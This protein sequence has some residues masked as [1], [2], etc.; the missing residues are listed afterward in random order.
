MLRTGQSP[1]RT[2]FGAGLRSRWNESLERANSIVKKGRT[3]RAFVAGV[4]C[5]W[6]AKRLDEVNYGEVGEI[7]AYNDVTIVLEASDGADSP[8]VK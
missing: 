4:A 7:A 6:Q 8:F 3:T 5:P 2:S 1:I